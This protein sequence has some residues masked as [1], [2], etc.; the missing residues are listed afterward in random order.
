MPSRYFRRSREL[1]STPHTGRDLSKLDEIELE[2]EDLKDMIRFHHEP[3]ST[4]TSHAGVTATTCQGTTSVI[5]ATGPYQLEDARWHLLT[6]VV[7]NAPSRMTYNPRS[8][9]FD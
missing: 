2:N 8:S 4:N 9:Y 5:T 3:E 7:S 6:N 1:F